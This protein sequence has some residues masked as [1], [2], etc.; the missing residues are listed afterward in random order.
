MLTIDLHYA[1][2]LL[3]PYLMDEIHLHDYV[4]AKEVL[5]I[6]LQKA[7]GTP[8]TTITKYGCNSLIPVN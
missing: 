6:I 1:K 8:T 5:N 2:A 3:N 7:I 4:N